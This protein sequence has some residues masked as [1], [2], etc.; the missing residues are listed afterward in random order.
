MFDEEFYP[1]PGEVIKK[2][3]EPYIEWRDAGYAR[4][5]N[6]SKSTVILE[7]SAGHGDILDYIEKLD[8]KYEAYCLEIN[9]ESQAILRDKKYSII[10]SDFL[11][12]K[13]PYYFNLIL[14]NPPFSNGVDHLL[15]AWEILPEGDICCL[16]N[17]S[18][19]LNPRSAKR[20]LLK[21]IIDEHGSFELLGNCFKESQRETGVEVALVRLKKPIK[22]DTG[23]NFDYEAVKVEKLEQ[24][25]EESP[26]RLLAIP[27][28]LQTLED[29]YNK[30]LQLARDFVLT[31]S[32]MD[33][34]GKGISL[35]SPFNILNDIG[36]EKEDKYNRFIKDFTMSAWD[37]LFSR[38]GFERYMAGKVKRDFRQICEERGAALFNKESIRSL[39]KDLI[40]NRETIFKECL[41][42][43]TENLTKYDIKNKEAVE[44]WKTND[45]YK[46][47][48]R[49]IIPYCIQYDDCLGFQHGYGYNSDLLRDL[50]S[51]LCQLSNKSIDKIIQID[52]ALTDKFAE[53][54]KGGDC[55]CESTF[56]KIKFFKKQTIHLEF[57]DEE[58]R[59][60]LNIKM[61]EYRGWELPEIF[62]KREYKR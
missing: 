57:I 28:A 58:L 27:D 29:Q 59:Q 62:N 49:V 43:V 14:M 8:L 42:D 47:N 40:M 1:T 4:R 11:S 15:H 45:A 38:F 34:Y 26:E 10:G 9:L 53:N 61:A 6:L 2:M 55:R 20:E 46:I 5:F 51:V 24:K 23:F 30:V 16:L 32:K 36:G 3:I 35:R 33:F 48:K 56:F 25:E 54:R 37:S 21:S 44:G 18:T 31:A 50:D 17:A 39:L 52:R 7:P 13:I 41:L 19:I 22:K 60:D 12:E